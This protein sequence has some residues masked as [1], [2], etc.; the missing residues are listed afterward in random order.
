MDHDHATGWH[1]FASGPRRIADVRVG[2]VHRQVV[3]V[4]LLAPVDPVETFW[5]ALVAFA[6]L[7]PLGLLAQG[8]AIGLERGAATDQLQATLGLEH[9]DLVDLRSGCGF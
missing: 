1:A 3:A 2:H 4:A 9:Q 5:R 7:G 8:D 6:Q